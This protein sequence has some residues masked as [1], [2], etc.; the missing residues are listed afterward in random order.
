MTELPQWLR[1]VIERVLA[2]FRAPQQ[3][4]PD[5]APAEPQPEPHI[6]ADVLVRAT[7]CQRLYADLYAEHLDAAA[8][9]WGIDTPVRIAAW[10]AQLAYESMLFS[11]V[12]E[13]LYY[14]TPAR[15]I[16]VWPSRFRLPLTEREE[17]LDTFGDGKRNARRYVRQPERLANYVYASRM[18]NGNE[19]SGDGWLYRGRGLTMLTGR[20]NYSAYQ[21]ASRQL[22]VGDPSLVSAPFGA[23]NAAGWY[24]QHRA[25]NTY[26]DAQDW[27]GLTRAIN[28]GTTGIDARKKM[29]FAA[30]EAVA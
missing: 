20:D 16:A 17:S 10:L 28:G 14:T 30:L 1:V 26:A 2:L 13:S 22:V 3:S 8:K 7:G 15:L 27:T 12:E 9:R 6:T 25:L 21:L 23:A 29:I 18:G 4:R 19:D 5:A 11:R 24:W